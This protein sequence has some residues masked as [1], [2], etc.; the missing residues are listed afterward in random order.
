MAAGA[1]TKAGAAVVT[2]VRVKVAAESAV[3]GGMP[4]VSAV[5]GGV[6]AGAV[7]GAATFAVLVMETAVS[8]VRDEVPLAH[9]ALACLGKLKW[10]NCTYTCTKV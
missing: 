8:A 2:A 6:A 4:A 7:A 9:L 10:F 5:G 3:G 1:V